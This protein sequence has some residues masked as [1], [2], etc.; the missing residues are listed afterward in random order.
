MGRNVEIKAPIASVAALLPSVAALATSGPTEIDQDDTF[1]RC[2]TGRLKLRAFSET[3]GELIFYRRAGLHGPKVSFYVISPTTSPGTLRQLLTLAHGQVGRVE[4]HRTL[5]FVG[6]TRVHL[7]RV[8]GLGDFLEL[9]VVLNEGEGNEAGI[10]EAHALMERLGVQASH[11]IKD[12]YVD[13]IRPVGDPL[14]RADTLCGAGG[15]VMAKGNIKIQD[16]T[17]CVGL[18]TGRCASTDEHGK[19]YECRASNEEDAVAGLQKK[20]AEA[21]IDNDRVGATLLPMHAQCD[22]QTDDKLVMMFIASLF[23]I[24]KSSGFMTGEV[25]PQR[26]AR[27]IGHLLNDMG[28]YGLMKSVARRVLALLQADGIERRRELEYCWDRIGEWRA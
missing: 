1:F 7:D 19:V 8:K 13:L 22:G 4:K 12:S 6:R 10:A 27:E 14:V 5:F 23:H 21:N 26:Q 9:E 15:S 17:G 3:S 20:I 2:E 28:G 25:K 18:N 24:G 11:L 16:D